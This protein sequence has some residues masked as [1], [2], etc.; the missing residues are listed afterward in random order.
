[1]RAETMNDTDRLAIQP[2]MPTAAADIRVAFSCNGSRQ[3]V[4]ANYLSDA[5]AP[6][7]VTHFD[8]DVFAPNVSI[9][10]LL[11][12]ARNRNGAPEIFAHLVHTPGL[13]RDLNLSPLPT[14]SLDIDSFAWT[15]SRARWSMLFDYVFVWHPSLAPLYE[16]AGHP[17]VVVLPHA[18]DADLFPGSSDCRERQLD[19]GWVGGFGY[20]QYERRGRIIPALA[21]RFKM[22]DFA[23]RYSKQETADVYKASKI[24]VNVSRE[25]FPQDA[26]MRCYEAMGAGALLITGKPSELSE[27]GFRE[28]EHYVAWSNEAEITN[29][30]DY[31]LRHDKE[32]TEIARAGQNLTLSDFTYQRCRDK[33]IAVLRENRGQFFAPA[34]NWPPEDV[35]LVYLEYYYRYQLL[36]AVLEEAALLKKANSRAYW[37]ALPMVLKTLRH[38]LGRSLL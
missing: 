14:V 30:V 18:V 23:R 38:A 29:L 4:T 35:A 21:A 10:R 26:N 28:G 34:R 22:N 20:A 12:S 27:W 24:V 6:G 33:M 9:L 32:R 3:H 16:A 19:L 2:G 7:C 5:F 37:K 17:K 25:D 15:S 31:Y 1:M 36:E 8:L 11:E 13:P